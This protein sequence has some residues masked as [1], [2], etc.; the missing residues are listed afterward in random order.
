MNNYEEKVEEYFKLVYPEFDQLSIDNKLIAIEDE[1]LIC[2]HFEEINE[3]YN[4][5]MKE[6]SYFQKE[7][8]SSQ[9]ILKEIIKSIKVNDYLSIL[10]CDCEYNELNN[11]NKKNM[12]EDK[13][14]LIDHI[15]N[16]DYLFN[17]YI[18][19]NESNKEINNQELLKEII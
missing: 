14:F 18:N 3:A 11:D 9:K 12:L 16:I 1:K 17:I 5:C 8:Y 19:Q 15:D 13:R 4:K 2:E 6:G 7:G 10:Y